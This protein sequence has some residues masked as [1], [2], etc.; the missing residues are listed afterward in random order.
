MTESLL[1]K[2]MVF[3][4]LP[5]ECIET[6]EPIKVKGAIKREQTKKSKNAKKS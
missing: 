3:S 5:L 2:V 1:N 4:K 6:L